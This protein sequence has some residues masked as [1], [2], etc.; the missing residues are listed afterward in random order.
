M[1]TD[2]EDLERKLL[3][4]ANTKSFEQFI[5]EAIQVASHK[6]FFECHDQITKHLKK[7]EYSDFIKLS[8][9]SVSEII[10][11]LPP[12]IPI[13][14]LRKFVKRE[15]LDGLLGSEK[16]DSYTFYYF[17]DSRYLISEP[18]DKPSKKWTTYE[19]KG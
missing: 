18:N 2:N 12:F 10:P 14:E 5:I 15:A 11:C 4:N 19:Y 6:A 9:V 7:V 8:A 13:T 1:K 3:D 16:R 17:K